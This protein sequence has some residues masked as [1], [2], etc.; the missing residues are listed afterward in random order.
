LRPPAR[1]SGRRREPRSRGTSRP[2]SRGRERSLPWPRGACKSCR[3]C[4]EL[5]T[6]SCS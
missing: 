3:T 4:N 6:H 1:G 5:H 2:G